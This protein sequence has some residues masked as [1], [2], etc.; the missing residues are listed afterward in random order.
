MF[1][2]GAR[3]KSVAQASHAEQDRWKMISPQ[4]MDF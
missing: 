2:C 1:H 4:E 3:P